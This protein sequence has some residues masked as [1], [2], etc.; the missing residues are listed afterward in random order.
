M[1]V[2]T[3]E[4]LV[5]A[6]FY[7][8]ANL[9]DVAKALPSVGV[10]SGEPRLR[11]FC[12]NSPSI[13]ATFLPLLSFPCCT[14]KC[15]PSSTLTWPAND[16]ASTGDA[17][18][19]GFAFDEWGTSYIEVKFGW[20]QAIPFRLSISRTAGRIAASNSLES[21]KSQIWRTLHRSTNARRNGRT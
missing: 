12:S 4:N 17:A 2:G 5:C 10:D 13:F 3:D 7:T 21:P 16:S 6:G 8:D 1:P 18:L 9:P 14:M 15:R 11:C 20:S 19:A